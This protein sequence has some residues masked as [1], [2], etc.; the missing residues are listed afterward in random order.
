MKKETKGLTTRELT[1]CALFA[2]LIAVGAFIKIDIPLPMY[3]MHFT[4]QWFFVLMAG[5]LLGKK[6]ATISVVVYLCIGLVGVPV[7]AAGG[8][9]AYIFR[10]G[11][12]FLLGF[13]L[14]AYIIGALTDAVKKFHSV[15]L[16]LP[17]MAGLV[18]YYTV[19]AI[20]FY[21]INNF[22]VHTPVTWSVV[23]V[24]YC[25][26]TV[27]PDM[28]LCVSAATFAIKLRPAFINILNG[29]GSRKKVM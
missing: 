12:G 24:N 2:A 15:A 5:F 23:V 4:L 16:L 18:A 3:T 6:L 21:C 11:F 14:A 28:I 25:L 7:F 20:Y 29:Y 22:Y 13:A 19:G 1:T 26:I 9:P 10:P 27:I 8:G 17:A